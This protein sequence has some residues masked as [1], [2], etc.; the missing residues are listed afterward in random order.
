MNIGDEVYLADGHLCQYAGALDGGQHAVRHV[1]ES[2]GEPWV[3]DRITVV[4][5]VFKKA[6]VEVLDARVSERRG[7]LSEIDERLSAARQEALTL[8]RQKVATAKAIA[9]CRPAEIVAAWLAGKVTHFVMLDSD[10]G[11][12]LRPANAA[13][14][15]QYGNGFAPA[16]ELKVTL[17]KPGGATP[18][19]YRIGREGHAGVPCLSEEEGKAALATEWERFW[20]TKRQRMPWQPELPVTRCREA[21]MP[22]PAWYLE[23]ME[24]DKRA[25]AQK[26]LTDA[27][28]VLDEAKAELAAIA[29]AT[30][31][32]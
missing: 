22:V 5:A 4:G 9:A 30:P 24:N 12:S 21:G 32:A 18:W 8:E 28:K 14:K 11:P 25:A 6:P 13:L 19:T 27:Q 20:T 31:T 23:Q 15:K 2:D 7:E 26:R 1:Y 10:A 17:D 16:D 29:S 3:S